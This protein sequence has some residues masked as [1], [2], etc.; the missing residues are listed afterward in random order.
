MVL[1]SAFT[2]PAAVDSLIRASS[3]SRAKFDSL[4]APLGQPTGPGLEL[5]C[6]E[7]EDRWALCIC[8]VETQAWLTPC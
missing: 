7:L 4:T 3:Q 1:T 2:S 8:D 5:R 6:A